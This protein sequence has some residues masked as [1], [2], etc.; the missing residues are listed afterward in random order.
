MDAIAFHTLNLVLGDPLSRTDYSDANIGAVFYRWPCGCNAV[1][2]DGI[3]CT[4]LTWCEA[5]K[6]LSW[7]DRDHKT[8]VKKSRADTTL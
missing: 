7:P 8:D 5:H 1:C 3:K 2:A 4:D 6:D